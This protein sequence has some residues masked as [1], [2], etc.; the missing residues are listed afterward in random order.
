MRRFT[1]RR[2][3]LTFRRKKEG[4]VGPK[5]SKVPKITRTAVNPV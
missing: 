1:I 3:Y 4:L 2:A 5:I